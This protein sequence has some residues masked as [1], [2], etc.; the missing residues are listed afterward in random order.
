MYIWLHQVASILYIYFHIVLCNRA[1]I[2]VYNIASEC[3]G[4]SDSNVPLDCSASFFLPCRLPCTARPTHK[5]AETCATTPSHAT[6]QHS[7]HFCQREGIDVVIRSHQFVR[8]GYKAGRLRNSFHGWV[9]V[10]RASE[11]WLVEVQGIQE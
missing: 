8:Q 7:R 1:Y 2:S 5:D 6:P 11:G 3:K 4:S 9:K 10:P